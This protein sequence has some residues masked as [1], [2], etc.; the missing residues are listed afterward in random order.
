MSLLIAHFKNLKPSIPIRQTRLFNK[1]SF[2][3]KLC[4]FDPDEAP[5]REGKASENFVMFIILMLI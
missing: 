2:N 4:L 3:I 5:E 1:Q